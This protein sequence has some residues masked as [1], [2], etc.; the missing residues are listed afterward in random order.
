MLEEDVAVLVGTAHLG[1]LGFSA[2]LRNSSTASMLHI[3]FRSRSPTSRSLILVRGAEAVE[4]VQEGN[5]AS[6][7]HRCATGDRSMTSWTELSASMA[8]PVWRQA[9]T[10]L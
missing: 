1:V 10:S 7:A 6:M 3:S 2:F 4:E 9:M 8:K 5:V